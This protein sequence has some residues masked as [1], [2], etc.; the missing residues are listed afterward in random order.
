MFSLIAVNS[1]QLTFS[2]SFFLSAPVFVNATLCAKLQTFCINSVAVGFA[3]FVG[4]NGDMG[5]LHLN[6]DTLKITFPPSSSPFTYVLF[7]FSLFFF[8]SSPLLFSLLNTPHCS[9]DIFQL[10]FQSYY[11]IFLIRAISLSNTSVGS[12]LITHVPLSKVIIIMSEK[13]TLT[14]GRIL[15][16]VKTESIIKRIVC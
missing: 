9:S 1:W 8:L 5:I 6:H 12:L 4:F 16:T 3:N 11:Y 15:W 13:Q 10:L 2:S 7:L 14:V